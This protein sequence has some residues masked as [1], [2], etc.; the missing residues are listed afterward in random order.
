MSYNIEDHEDYLKN[1]MPFDMN[2][3]KWQSLQERIKAKV[4]PVNV[5]PIPRK[6][7]TLRYTAIGSVAAGLI[8]CFTLIIPRGHKPEQGLSISAKENA[9]QRLDQTIQGLNEDELNWIHQVNENDISEQD[10]YLENQV[11]L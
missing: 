4:I 10:E 7:K 8:L 2:E 3:E 6:K 5:V 1:K 9:E 11:Q